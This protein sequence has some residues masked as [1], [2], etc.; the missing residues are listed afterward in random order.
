MENYFQDVVGLALGLARGDEVMLAN[1]YAE[2]SDFVRFNGGR[3]RQAGGVETR[4]LSIDLI[5]GS[6]HASARTTLAGDLEVDRAR[7][8]RIVEDLR[9]RRA[10][11]PEDPHLLYSTEVRSTER[12]VESRLPSGGQALAEIE[13]AAG[14]R[15]LVGIYAAGGIYQG[16]ANSLGQRNWYANGSFNLDWSFVHS[17]DK[18][19][20]AN[21]AG[22]EWRPETLRQKADV[23][24][25]Q[26]AV[27]ARPPH[28]IR[29][30]RYRVV[31]APAALAE[32]LSLLGWGGFG[33]RAHRTKT[34]PLLR[35]I[36][37]EA[38]LDPRVRLSENFERGLAPDFQEEGFLRPPEVPLIA[39]G[40]YRECLASPR[41]A[42]EYG[43]PTN[44]AASR[45]ARSRSI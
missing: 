44:G 11:V 15:D 13:T 27:L 6:R 18:A 39:D 5:H 28:A 23:A 10:H 20:A 45:R 32:F 12:R 25:E 29:P 40:R 4:S 35:M 26:L 43:V 31:L 21:Y 34:T 33:L 3:V 7:L 22:F 1:F 9:D 24:L 8:V 37:D 42:A 36:E 41:S 14:G 19:V 17:S 2:E 38:R 16:F 30:G